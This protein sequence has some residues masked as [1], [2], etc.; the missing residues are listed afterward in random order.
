MQQRL[1]TLK[2]GAIPMY[3]RAGG[4]YRNLSCDDPEDEFEIPAECF[5][6]TCI[7]PTSNDQLAQLMRV[8]LYWLLDS[9]P[10]GILDFWFSG[11]MRSDAYRD[12]PCTELVPL[13]DETVKAFKSGNLAE[14][15]VRSNHW[16][17]V[18]CAIPYLSKDGDATAIAAKVG[19]MELLRHLHSLL[20]KWHENTC[21][22]AAGSG[23]LDCLLYTHERGGRW[24]NDTFFAAAQNGHLHILQYAHEK[25][26]RWP[27]AVCNFAALNGHL[28]CLIYLHQL[29]CPLDSGTVQQAA[30]NNHLECLQYA[31]ALGCAREE[32]ACCSA[33]KN[34]HLEALI[35]LRM[36]RTECGAETSFHAAQCADKACLEYLHQNGCPWD[37]RA[38]D[39]AALKGSINALRYAL[40]NGCPYNEARLIRSAVMGGSLACITYLVK[41]RHLLVVDQELFI[42]A[43]FAR[44]MECMQYLIDH[45]CPCATAR[46][47]FTYEELLRLRVLLL[48][49]D[50]VRCVEFAV[51]QGWKMDSRFIKF[52]K[53]IQIHKGI[54]IMDDHVFWLAQGWLLHKDTRL[55]ARIRKYFLVRSELST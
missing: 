13:L 43:L 20:F 26:F 10:F 22:L 14:R 35:M 49:A 41:E 36:Y 3:L 2:Y 51:K 29:G 34:G 39:Q 16:E 5:L 50:F 28:H 37:E 45:G 31:L 8:T 47:R 17:V 27:P 4:F 1:I 9:I 11:K 48:S 18:I 21:T 12:L 44:N 6:G 24:N 38:A 42:L 7:R 23:H 52:A 46:V 55:M 25:G 53:H 32:A 30:Q 15:L 40:E 54:T 19:H 33:A